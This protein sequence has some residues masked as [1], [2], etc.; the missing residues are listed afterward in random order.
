MKLKH[1]A[2][3]RLLDRLEKEIDLDHMARCETIQTD[4]W[5]GKPLPYIPCVVHPPAAETDWIRYPFTE[6]WD[7]VEKHFI[8]VLESVYHGVLL[9]DDRLYQLVPSYGVVNIPELF[10]VPSHISDA[11]NSMS[12]GLNDAGRV[13]EVVARGVPDFARHPHNRKI[14]DFYD[15]AK[16]VLASCEKLSRAVHFTLPDT[17]GPFDLACLVWGRDILYALHDDEELVSRLLDVVTDAYIAFSRHHKTRIGI[18]MN[19][20]YHVCGLKLVRGGVRIC[21]DSAVLISGD[22]YRRLAAVQ[23]ARAYAPFEG[24]WAHYCG[25]G[26][27]ILDAVLDTPGVNALH[28]GN[29]DMHD[30]VDVMRKCA[31]RGTVLYWSGS[32]DRLEEARLAAPDAKLMLVLENRY[33][34]V[35]LPDAY[36]RLSDA[37][38]GR[39]L[40]QAPW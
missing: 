15:F 29:P 23:N 11:G 35:S 30:F 27:H 31:K 1:P 4:L 24:G 9:K 14:E 7:D 36:R 18:P 37:R 33:A 13:R 34:P 22:H 26:N 5:N 16:A 38:A 2:H 12:E 10:G 25:N 21:D 28:L 17:Q 19:R 3:Q 8:T 6:C 32:L 40:P 20:E 39:S